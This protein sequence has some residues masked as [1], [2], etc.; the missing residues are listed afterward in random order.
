MKISRI[1]LTYLATLL[2]LFAVS[3]APKSVWENAIYKEDTTLGSGAIT[4]TVE[5]T[6]EDTTVTFTV[7]TDKT[8]LG[9][10]LLE[11]GIIAGENGAFGL[12][13]KTVNGILADY[14]VDGYYWSLTKNGEYM[15]TGV[16]GETVVNGAH[17]EFT[18]TR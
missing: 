7:H 2:L 11:H 13:V 8:T 3:C 18:R 14:D 1:C 15:Q 17:Y 6:A 4:V 5:V 10:A 12:Y 9:D 16:D